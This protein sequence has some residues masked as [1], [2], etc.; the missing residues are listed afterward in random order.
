MRTQTAMATMTMTI[1]S[2][3]VQTLALMKEERLSMALRMPG[4]LTP[5]EAYSPLNLGSTKTTMPT[6][7]IREKQMMIVG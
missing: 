5:R 1:T 2:T 3:R 6:A 7:M 4:V